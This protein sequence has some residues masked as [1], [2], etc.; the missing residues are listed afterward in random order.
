MRKCTSAENLKDMNEYA[1][2]TRKRGRSLLVVEG[3]HERNKLFWLIFQCFPEININMDD[4]S[5]TIDRAL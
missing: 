3:N 4:I 1:D 2:E 5:Q